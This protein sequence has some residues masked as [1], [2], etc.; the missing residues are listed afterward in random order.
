MGGKAPSSVNTAA[1]RK[2]NVAN[3][4]EHYTTLVIYVKD[5]FK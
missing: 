1:G 2:K 4:Q 5:Y 3:L